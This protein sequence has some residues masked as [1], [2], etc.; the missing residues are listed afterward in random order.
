MPKKKSKKPPILDDRFV[1][2]SVHHVITMSNII[3]TFLEKFESQNG[4]KFE[5][6]KYNMLFVDKAYSLIVVNSI[7]D[8]LNNFLFKYQG[9]NNVLIDKI[10]MFKH[11]GDPIFEY[12]NRWPDIKRY[13]NNVLAHNFRIKNENNISVFM[14]NRLYNYIVPETLIDFLMLYRCIEQVSLI[15]EQIFAKEYSLALS[16]VENYKHSNSRLQSF[17]DED[18]LLRIAFQEVDSRFKGINK[19]VE[20][21]E[22]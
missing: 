16:I 9:N 22:P 14:S 6:N 2:E 18:K 1:I 20:K 10:K 21:T 4:D 7:M 8:E 3:I 13:R 17:Q 15:I 19:L 12:L 5:T 11:I